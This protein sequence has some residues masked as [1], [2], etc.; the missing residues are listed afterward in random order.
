VNTGRCVQTKENILILD[1]WRTMGYL[2]N[3][4]QIGPGISH[5]NKFGNLFTMFYL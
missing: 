4:D 2:K 1:E 3:I 5:P